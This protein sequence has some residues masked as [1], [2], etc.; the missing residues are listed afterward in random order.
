MVAAR[1]DSYAAAS[2]GGVYAGIAG[3]GLPAWVPSPGQFA[4]VGAST[5]LSA[6]P[7]GWP[8]SD[9]GGPFSNWAGGFWN[10]DFGSMG[11]YVVFGSGHL[12]AGQP[13][14]AGV[15]V[16]DA[17]T[18]T[19]V[20]RNVPPTPMIE[21]STLP[22]GFENDYPIHTYDGLI[23]QPTAAG[24]GAD[25]S[26]IR[27]FTPGA[28]GA[29]RRVVYRHDLSLPSSASTTVIATVPT[30][31]TS[32]AETYP[33]AAA[34]YGRG[35]YWLM[36]NNGSEKLMFVSFADWSVT[37][38]VMDFAAYGDISMVYIPERDC[39]VALGRV[40]DGGVNMGVFVS[41]IV[42]GVPQYWSPVAAQ[43]GTPPADR[44]CGGEWVPSLGCIVSYEA[45]GSYTVH[46]L[47]PPANLTAGTWAWTSETLTGVGGAIPCRT[48]SGNNGAWSRMV[49]AEN[50]GC[51]LWADSVSKVMQAWRLTGM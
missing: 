26:M 32:G 43:S 1:N 10:P 23:L 24:G 30:A 45:A 49:Y 14:F 20:G 16:W 42:A 21:G 15:W 9:I 36:N 8:N 2:G 19:W 39:L 22:A 51:M 48:T 46:K 40:G 6:V 5:L 18:A 33:M 11:G 50:L 27:H 31:M 29:N 3:S 12:S 44:R 13:L 47:T 37:N 28:G 25:G 38:Y 17:G 4:D 35:G 41:P 34:D 7:P